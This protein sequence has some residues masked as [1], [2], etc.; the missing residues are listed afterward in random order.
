MGKSAS[1]SLSEIQKPHHMG[2]PRPPQHHLP[3]QSRYNTCLIMFHLTT[4][5]KKN[6]G[7]CSGVFWTRTM[8]YAVNTHTQIYIYINKGCIDLI[9]RIS[10]GSDPVIFCGS[11][12]GETRKKRFNKPTLRFN[13]LLINVS[14]LCTSQCGLGGLCAVTQCCFKC[15]LLRTVCALHRSVLVHFIL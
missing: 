5:A 2:R 12:I 9:L 11:G 4:L 3:L 14:S 8:E 6:Y 10:I 1:P 15:I 7:Q 13:T